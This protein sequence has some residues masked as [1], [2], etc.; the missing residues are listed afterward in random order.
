MCPTPKFLLVFIRQN[1]GKPIAEKVSVSPFVDV[2]EHIAVGLVVL[3]FV[4]LVWMHQRQDGV[5]V[6]LEPAYLALALLLETD[7]GDEVQVGR[8][9]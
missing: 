3:L 1:S 6:A 5:G 7:V 9:A 2:F 4:L 8:D